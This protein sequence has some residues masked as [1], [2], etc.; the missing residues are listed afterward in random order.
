MF[1]FEFGNVHRKTER[2][3]T[4]RYESLT[5]PQPRPTRASRPARA[6]Q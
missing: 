1:K 2:K 3:A 4:P 6:L 5:A